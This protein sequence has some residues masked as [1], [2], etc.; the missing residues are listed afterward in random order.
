MMSHHCS[1]SVPTFPGTRANYV[2]NIGIKTFLEIPLFHREGGGLR[3]HVA[4]PSND[5]CL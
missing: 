2:L 4:G 5:F 3:T 1:H